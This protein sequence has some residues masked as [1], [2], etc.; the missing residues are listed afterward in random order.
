MDIAT[1]VS[2]VA[3]WQYRRSSSRWLLLPFISAASL[4]FLV[5]NRQEIVQILVV[6]LL[7]A[8][9]RANLSFGR[10]LTYAVAAL[11]IYYVVIGY[12][13][14]ARYG[15]SNISSSIDPLFLPAWVALGDL[16]GA[17]KLAHG[18]LDQ[19]G[20]GG[21]GFRYT[22]PV[23]LSVIVPNIEEYI[24][25]HGAV[26]IQQKFTL[27][28]TAQSIAAPFS[29]YADGGMPFVVLVAFGTGF[30][31]SA[32]YRHASRD[33]SELATV[34]YLTLWIW[35][36][37]AVRSGAIPVSPILIFQWLFLVACL[38]DK[39]GIPLVPIVPRAAYFSTIL[40]SVGVAA[41]RL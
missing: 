28:I 17:M 19:V 34:L 32:L 40:I 30:L 20:P 39:S 26:L 7:F 36:C 5:Q 31:L 18:V 6:C 10:L 22:L 27:S 1:I 12:W 23:Y 38:R 29:Y 41:V 13:F 15:A 4:Q 21:L 2:I 3:F 9:F 37:W 8:G 25:P 33:R 11:V 24:G 14:V 35:C 16:I